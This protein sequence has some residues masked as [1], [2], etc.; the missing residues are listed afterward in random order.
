[1][2][3]FVS[4]GLLLAV[5]GLAGARGALPPEVGL[6]SLGG[7]FFCLLCAVLL[8]YKSRQAV[9]EDR[10]RAAS[11]SMLVIMA[12]MLKDQDEETLERI[13]HQGGPAAEAASMLL[14]KRRER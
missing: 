12:S 14:K 1:M 8:G 5:S 3:F 9:I 7:F 4:L 2:W 10:S 13:V 6:L 11:G